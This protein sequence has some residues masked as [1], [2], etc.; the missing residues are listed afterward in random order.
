[1]TTMN[2]PHIAHTI[3]SRDS[4]HIIPCT[5]TLHHGTTIVNVSTPT[6]Q[7]TIKKNGNPDLCLGYGYLTV[8]FT[9]VN[10]LNNYKI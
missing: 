3:P 6:R 2:G 1:M 9:L 10:C 5:I 8:S 7:L 4:H